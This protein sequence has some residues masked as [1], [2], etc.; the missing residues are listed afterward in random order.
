MEKRGNPSTRA[1]NKYNAK[2]YDR[3]NIFIPKGRKAAIEARANELNESIN[4]YTNRLYRADLGV[5]EDDW[6]L[7]KNTQ[8]TKRLDA[9][10]IPEVDTQDGE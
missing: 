9:D 8:A 10:G 4:S 5:S 7:S 6:G 3:L 2:A 1:K